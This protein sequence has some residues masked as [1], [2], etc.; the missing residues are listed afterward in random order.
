M[1]L[2]I[3]I[4]GPVGAGKSSIAREVARRL[5]ILHLDTGAMYRA[6]GYA[7]LSRKISPED[8]NAL[9]VLCARVSIE[10]RYLD[11]R[12]QTLV[13]G[14]DVSHLI[15]APEVGMAAS[16][17]SRFKAVRCHMVA[18]QRA[19]A[20]ETSMVVDGRDI[21][22]NVLPDANI[23]IFLTAAPEERARRRHLEL[24]EAGGKDTY[25]SV[26]SDL[27][28]RDM[29]DTTRPIDPLRPAEDAMMLDS[30]HLNMDQVVEKILGIVEA[31]Y[32]KAKER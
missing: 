4:D 1:P 10:V 18:L 7:A 28:K 29:Q 24:R 30:T 3:A 8:E 20:R 13:D 27:I 12:Q 25:E 16:T 31:R 23:K 14:L 32:G 21:G 6:V 22:T 26:L 5:N 9:N 11:G 17:V 2:N 15:R 19:L